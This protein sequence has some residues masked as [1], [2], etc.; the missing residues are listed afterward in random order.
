MAKLQT[1]AAIAAAIAALASSSAAQTFRSCGGSAE[2]PAPGEA[3]FSV[4]LSPRGSGGLGLDHAYW[5]WSP[6]GNWNVEVHADFGLQRGEVGEPQQFSLGFASALNATGEQ[7]E[8]TL[9]LDGVEHWRG[10]FSP[11]NG[12]SLDAMSHFALYPADRRGGVGLDF[13]TAFF[14]AKSLRLRVGTASGKSLLDETVALP[15]RSEW[16]TLYSQTMSEALRI[17]SQPE[18]TC[19]ELPPPPKVL[20]SE[21]ASPTK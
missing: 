11:T 3:Q 15:S 7:A 6:A 5:E 8:I 12:E 10:P 13:L 17:A 18:N 21:P 9:L 2:A 1:I 4:E 19:N 20:S 16:Q 14:Q